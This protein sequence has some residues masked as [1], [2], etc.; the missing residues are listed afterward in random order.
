MIVP[1]RPA[2][3][4]GRVRH[5]GD[6]VGFVVAETAWAARDAAERVAVEYTPLG[7]VVEAKAAL[8]ADAPSIWDTGNE[9]YRFQRGDQAAVQAALAAAEFVVDIEV[10]NNRLVIAPIETR[11]GIGRWKDG[12]FDLFVTTASVHAIRD[13]LAGVFGCARDRSGC[14]RRMW[15]AGSASRTVCIRNG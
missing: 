12:V 14:R 13:Q 11:A 1:P 10:V 4:N 7:S 2:L 5:V 6:P 15:A 8:A 3:A 9:L